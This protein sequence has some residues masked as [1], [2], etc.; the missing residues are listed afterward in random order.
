MAK[1]RQRQLDKMERVEKVTDKVKPNF[2]F[3]EAR[4]SSRFVVETEN[5]VIGYDEPLT[6]P[7]NLTLERGQKVALLGVNGLGKSTLLKTLLGIIKPVSGKVML[8]DYL[9]TGYF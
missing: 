5:L 2:S 4:A 9:E 8:G 6:R 3:S 7:L 1:S